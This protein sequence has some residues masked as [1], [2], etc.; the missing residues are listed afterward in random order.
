MA[1]WLENYYELEALAPP[2]P[3][4]ERRRQIDFLDRIKIVEKP[5]EKPHAAPPKVRKRPRG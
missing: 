3:L 1:D 2:F 5:E 4:R